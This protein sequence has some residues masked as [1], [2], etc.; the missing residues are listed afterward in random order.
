MP[1]RATVIPEFHLGFAVGLGHVEGLEMV[2]ACQEMTSD[3]L[4]VP[5]FDELWDLRDSTEVDISPEGMDEMVASAHKYASQIG[6]NRC[7]FV[8]ARES[9]KP[10]L[11]LFAWL[12]DDLPR[13]YHT[14]RTRDE[15]LAWL[16]LPPDALAGVALGE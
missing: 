1:I 8:S 4:W 14:T 7:V 12:T 16:G 5:G 11:R 3:P 9:V 13:T 15:A 10:V 6:D 2:R